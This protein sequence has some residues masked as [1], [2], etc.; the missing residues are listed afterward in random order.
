MGDESSDSII[1]GSHSQC[2]Q[3]RPPKPEGARKHLVAVA[4]I[5]GRWRTR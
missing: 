5:G 2:N 1:P 4:G 3:M